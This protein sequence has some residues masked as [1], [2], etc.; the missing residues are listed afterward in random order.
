M[1]LAVFV[2]KDWEPGCVGHAVVLVCWPI[3]RLLMICYN[4]CASSVLCR[5]VTSPV[6]VKCKSTETH[7]SLIMCAEHM[8]VTDTFISDFIL[9]LNR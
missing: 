8:P 4:L 5:L 9:Q 6:T 2:L 3:I 7:T 1:S